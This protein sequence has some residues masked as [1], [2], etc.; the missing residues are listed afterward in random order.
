MH[1]GFGMYISPTGERYV[2]QWSS[3]QKHGAGR[4]I[5]NNGDFYDGEFQH[6]K[7]EGVG[8]YYHTREGN[9]YT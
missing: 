7:A 1:N 4:F 2:G 6:D 8:V 3:G 9:V 5:F